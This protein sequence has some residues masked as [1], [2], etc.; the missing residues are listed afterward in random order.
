[1]PETDTKS[2]FRTDKLKLTKEQKKFFQK[3]LISSIKSW[4]KKEQKWLF[5]KLKKN[6]SKRVIL[7]F[8]I[9][10]QWN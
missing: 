4:T 6:S 3:S 2:V 7:Q 8:K 9:V 5:K 1:M 10:E